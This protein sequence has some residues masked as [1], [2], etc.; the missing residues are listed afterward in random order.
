[1]WTIKEPLWEREGRDWPNRD[2]SRFV[3]AAGLRW[4][5]QQAGEG[6]VILLIHGTGAS[7]HSF[8]DLIPLLARSFTAIAPDLPGHGFTDA[9]PFRELSLCG[10]SKALSELLRKLDV[11][12]MLAVGHSAGAAILA[13]MSLDGA[14]APQAIVS[15]NGALLPFQGMARHLFSPAAKLLAR[16]PMLPQLFARRAADPETTKRLIRE[17]GSRIDATGIELYRR[18][19]SNPSHVASAFGMMA[20]WDLESLARDLPRLK[21]P[22]VVVTGGND[23]MVPP[24]EQRRVRILVRGA[25]LVSL[26]R[27]GHLAHEEQPKKFAELLMRLA[28]PP[29]R[30]PIS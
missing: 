7:T 24:E 6:P 15:L 25:E 17:T 8:R 1:M 19:A 26:P 21:T 9:P 30:P 5:L 18:L 11:R 29:E 16:L 12:P 13:R 2:A 14:V 27:L 10:M 20:N 28:S 4:H 22:L 23:L 3:K